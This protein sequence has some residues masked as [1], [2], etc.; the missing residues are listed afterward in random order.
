[1]RR[2][3]SNT[4]VRL[5]RQF[6]QLANEPTCPRAH[7]QTRSGKVGMWARGQVLVE[8]ASRISSPSGFSRSTRG[9]RRSRSSRVARESRTSSRPTPE[10]ASPATWNG[11][12]S[13][14]PSRDRGEVDRHRGATVGPV[15]TTG[16]VAGVP[17][18]PRTV[19]PTAAPSIP[20]GTAAART[21]GT[22]VP[23]MRT[24]VKC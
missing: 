20:A 4:G 10:R 21:V 11:S 2:F 7:L 15:V 8:S 13:E 22:T 18:T 5:F 16:R 6:N 12:A 14:L 9:T 1:M 17:A 24:T 23:F 3:V 19:D